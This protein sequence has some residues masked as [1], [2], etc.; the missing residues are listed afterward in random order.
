[1]NGSET[2]IGLGAILF[3]FAWIGFHRGVRAE[4]GT[5]ALI[6]GSRLLIERKGDWL[7]FVLNNLYRAILF[8][9]KGGLTTEDPSPIFASL[10]Q[11]RPLI[12]REATPTFLLVLFVLIII[13]AYTLLGRLRLFRGASSLLGALL[14][15]INGYLVTFFFLPLLPEDLPEPLAFVTKTLPLGGNAEIQTATQPLRTLIQDHGS[16]VAL[17]VVGLILLFV[18]RTIQPERG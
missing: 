14:G 16:Y 5:L 13:V 12:S 8:V 1:M 2:T 10:R 17:G 15:M 6:L 4:L 3:V 9:L 18:V 11:V 7:V